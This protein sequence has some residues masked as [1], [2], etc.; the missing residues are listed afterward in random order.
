MDHLQRLHDLFRQFPGIGQRQAK[1]FVYFLLS[2]TDIYRNDLVHEIT[3]LENK[4][5]LCQSCFRFFDKKNAKTDICSLCSDKSRQKQSFMILAKDTDLDAIEKSK[6]YKG[7]YFV[8]GGTVPLFEKAEESSRIRSKEL[9]KIVEMRA[10]DGM[11]EIIIALSLN[12]EGE[13]TREYI[14]SLIKPIAKKHGLKIY[15]LGRG[16]STGTELEYS[17]TETIKNALL[18]RK[19]EL[20]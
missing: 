19:Q 8:F 11:K 1:R 13:H 16:L 14:E 3:E 4:V 10:K 5:S 17:D 12:S 7:L 15:T 20:F 2:A 9:L 18:G 6:V